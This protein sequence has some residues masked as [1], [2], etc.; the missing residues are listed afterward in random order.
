MEYP[1]HMR[2][3]VA[4]AQGQYSLDEVPVP[5][6]GYGE[7]LLK[8]EACGICAGDVKATHNAARF[9]GGDGMPGFCK[10]PFI[11]GHEFLGEVAAVGDGV[12]AFKVGDRLVTEQIVPCGKC[13]YCAEGKYWLCDPHDV[14]GFKSHLNGGMAEY[15]LLPA[16]ARN[17][18]ISKDIP[19]EEAVLIEPYACSLRGVRQARIT[20]DDVVVLSGAGT[21][22]LGMIGAIRMRNPKKLIVLDMNDAR[23][24]KAKAF[25]ADE[26][27]NPGR[28]NAIQRVLDQTDG[29]GCDVYIEVTGHPNSVGQGLEMICKG[30]RFVE[31]SVFS[32]PAT[33]DWSIIGDTKEIVIYGS[34]LSPYCYPPTI[35]GIAEGKLPTAGVVTHTFALE[36]W[37]EAFQT[38]EGGKAI[39]VIIKP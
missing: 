10:P 24:E 3:L 32:A 31:F 12:E 1:R 33:V 4:H 7:I 23:L 9:W 16:N 35:E 37:E 36:Q 29:Y 30:G 6:P 26:V 11:P 21:L 27:L 8:V 13:R 39:K 25:G 28:D 14:Y 5:V 38:A 2:A 19:T 22:G 15:V 18:K 20:C 17:Y 34:Q